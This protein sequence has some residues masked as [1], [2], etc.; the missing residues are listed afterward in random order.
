[1][2]PIVLDVSAHRIRCRTQDFG[3]V[4]F[5][6]VVDNVKLKCEFQTVEA[7]DW[8]S[9][10]ALWVIS[11]LANADFIRVLGARLCYVRR[12]RTMLGGIV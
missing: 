5:R 3:F 4:A 11:G 8:F 7:S 10:S 12:N 2:R 1:V 6:E 9:R